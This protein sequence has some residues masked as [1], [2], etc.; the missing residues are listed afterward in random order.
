M[1]GIEL[2]ESAREKLSVRIAALFYLPAAA[3]GGDKATEN[4]EKSHTAI[5]SG[6]KRRDAGK[7]IMREKN[8]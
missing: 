7:A 5:A 1:Q 6:I 8:E 3:V 2:E 4:E